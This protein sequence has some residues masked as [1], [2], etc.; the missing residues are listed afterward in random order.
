LDH[1]PE[2]VVSDDD[3]RAISRGQFIRPHAADAAMLAAVRKG[4]GPIRVRDQAG[5][6]V[7]IA[8]MSEGRLAPDKVL[9]DG[10]TAATG[11]H[12]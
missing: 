10:A 3:V 9:V 6:L 11:A 8:T 12:A 2:L 7:A 5:H 1:L 4:D